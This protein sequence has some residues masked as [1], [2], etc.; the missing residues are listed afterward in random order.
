MATAYPF[1][2]YRYRVLIDGQMVGTFQE[3]SAPEAASDPIEYRE[4]CASVSGADRISGKPSGLVRY[5]NVTL[6][7]GATSSSEFYNWV[8][9]AG[10]GRVVRKNLTIS[11]ADDSGAELAKWTILSAWPIKYVAPESNGINKENVIELIELAH[12]GITRDP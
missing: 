9:E 6:K 5:G 2:M 12:E 3:I 8:K 4:G 11:L 7:W 10:G 1:R